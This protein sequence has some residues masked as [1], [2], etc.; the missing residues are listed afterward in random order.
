MKTEYQKCMDGDFFTA[1]PEML[2]IRIVASDFSEVLITQ[3]WKTQANV[4][5]L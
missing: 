1:D 5:K 3:I 4:K 2:Q